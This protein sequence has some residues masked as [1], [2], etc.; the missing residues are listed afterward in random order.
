LLEWVIL[1]TLSCVTLL[2]QTTMI[3]FVHLLHHLLLK[4][5]SMK[6]NLLC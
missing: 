6:L 2:A 5:L 1:R 4:Q 3:S